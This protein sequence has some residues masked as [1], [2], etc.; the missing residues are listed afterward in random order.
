M[1]KQPSPMSHLVPCHNAHLRNSI[2]EFLLDQSIAPLEKLSCPQCGAVMRNTQT[3]FTPFGT[4]RGVEFNI[5]GLSYLRPD[6]SEKHDAMD[7]LTLVSRLRVLRQEVSEIV[8]LNREYSE[9][10]QHCTFD[11][12][13]H[14]KRRRRLEE[15]KEELAAMQMPLSRAS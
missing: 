7:N 13:M 12:D 3:T 11:T 9:N 8:A 6:I 10:T 2:E 15:I 5:A 4:T 14:N 1:R